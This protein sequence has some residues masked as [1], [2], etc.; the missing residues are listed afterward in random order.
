MQRGETSGRLGVVEFGLA[1]AVRAYTCMLS[2]AQLAAGPAGPQG[3]PP[4]S[5][6]QWTTARP[7]CLPTC[8]ISNMFFVSKLS[9]QIGFNNSTVFY[10]WYPNLQFCRRGFQGVVR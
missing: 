5:V 8:N 6:L 10:L 4:H 1:A 7:L 3:C 2:C 9:L